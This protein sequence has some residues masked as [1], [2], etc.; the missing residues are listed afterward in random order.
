MSAAD[1]GSAVFRCSWSPPITLVGVPPAPRRNGSLLLTATGKR[2]RSGRARPAR[3]MK[4]EGLM[5]ECIQQVETH[6]AVLTRSATSH[7]QLIAVMQLYTLTG[8]R[9]GEAALYQEAIFKA[10]GIVPLVKLLGVGPDDS[11]DQSSSAANASCILSRLATVTSHRAAIVAAGGISALAV[12]TARERSAREA[13][14]R[15]GRDHHVRDAIAVAQADVAA[16]KVSK[17]RRC[18]RCNRPCPSEEGPKTCQLWGCGR[19]G[20]ELCC[21]H[22]RQEQQLQDRVWRDTVA[23]VGA[24]GVLQCSYADGSDMRA[25]MRAKREVNESPALRDAWDA[26]R[27]TLEAQIR[28]SAGR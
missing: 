13:L 17:P 5:L 3:E 21:A 6:V 27:C 18:S 20:K 7:E 9:N 26:L 12:L 10:G 24:C 19:P 25:D 23:H 14:K 22:M 11:P 28:R 4:R 2:D 16:T 1:T 15:L 8:T